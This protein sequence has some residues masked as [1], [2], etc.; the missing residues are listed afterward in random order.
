MLHLT[1]FLQTVTD[2]APFFIAVA[3]DFLY[4]F[5]V[6]LRLYGESVLMLLTLMLQSTIAVLFVAS[7]HAP[8]FL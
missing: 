8:F 6:L 5:I 3:L 2:L 4:V 1:Y 7:H